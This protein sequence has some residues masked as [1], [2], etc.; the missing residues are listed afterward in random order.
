MRYDFDRVIER[1]GTNSAKW[2]ETEALFGSADVL[3]MWV[4]DMDFPVARPITEAL[5]RRIRHEVWGYTRPGEGLLEA[6]V[7][8]IWRKYGWRVDPEW[9]QFTPGAVPALHAAIRAFTHPGDDVVIQG[10]VY[11]PFWAAIRNSGCAVAN[12]PLRLV[13]GR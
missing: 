1:R 2:D 3:P 7:D 12:N 9:I 13:D 4:A 8:R 11:Y 6:V 5:E 10:P